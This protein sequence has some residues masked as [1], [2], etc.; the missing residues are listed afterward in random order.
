MASFTELVTVI[1]GIKNVDDLDDFLTGLTTARE[2]AEF[3]QRLEIVKLL[4]A[5][6]SQHKIA[7]ELGVG[8]ATVGRG[9]KELAAGRFKI[10]REK[11]HE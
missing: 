3:S 7:Q 1:S 8:V 4:V 9:A 2:R 10:L 6:K 11:N 5:G